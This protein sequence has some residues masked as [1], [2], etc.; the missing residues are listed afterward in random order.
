MLEIT[1]LPTIHQIQLKLTDDYEIWSSVLS[2]I[3]DQSQEI[4]FVGINTIRLPVWAFL[5]CRADLGMALQRNNLEFSLDSEVNRILN[6]AL[7]KSDIYSR[8]ENLKL[9]KETDLVEKLQTRGF[10]RQLTS[11]QLRNIIKLCSLG[12]GATFSVPGAGKTTEALAFYLFMQKPDDKLLVVCPKN[13]FPAWEEQ[14]AICVG[15]KFKIVRLVGGI[16]E[17]SRILHVD[18]DI[19]LITYQQLPNVKEILAGYMLQH[20]TFMFLDESHRIKRGYE[21]Q[22]CNA[23][24]SLSHLPVA[25][26]IMSGTPL[27]NSSDDLIPQFSFVYPE[28]DVDSKNVK[29]KIKPIFVRTTKSE[30]NLPAL[31]QVLIPIYLQSKHQDLYELLRSEEARQLSKLRTKDKNSIRRIGKSVIRLLQLVSN[32]ALL[33]KDDIGWPD[34]LFDVLLE[35]DSPKIEYTCLRARQLANQ[36]KKTIIWSNF[37]ENVELLASRLKDLGADYIHGGVEAGSDEEEDTREQKIKRFHEDP[38]AFV[39]VA[40]PAACAEGISLH[41]VCHHAIYLDRNYNAAQF[42]Q[43]Q[44]RI[45][46]LGLSP[47]IETIIEILFSPHTVDE[48]VNRRLNKKIKKMAEVLDDKSLGPINLD[49]ESE[50]LD[51]EDIKDFLEIINHRG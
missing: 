20:P 26:L 34:S 25:K 3:Q 12:S 18:A 37:V 35:G 38:N 1:Y 39:L 45:H 41:T 47:D 24:L 17:I 4:S 43:S 11:Y 27:P 6:K 36:G 30:L 13:A 5:A 29:E 50:E 44:D 8:I 28:I 22:W 9:I 33:A 32:P 48:S 42:L 14:V 46:R 16:R 2:S 15:E 49:L 10:I 19:F 40:N 23:V 51:F 7:E 31:K 21:G